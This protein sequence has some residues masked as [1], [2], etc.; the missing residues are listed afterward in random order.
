MPHI[1]KVKCYRD[2]VQNGRARIGDVVYLKARPDVPMS[3][4]VL[5]PS[6]STSGH[7]VKVRW[8]KPDG[9]IEMGEFFS[10]ELS[11]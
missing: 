8:M 2:M 1:F 6:Y 7:I 4:C 11:M 9:T 5:P 3:V 10:N